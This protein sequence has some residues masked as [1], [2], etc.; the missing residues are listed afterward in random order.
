[1]EPVSQ[2]G[3]KPARAE[4]I[5]HVKPRHGDI[6]DVQGVQFMQRNEF[7]PCHPMHRVLDPDR[8]NSY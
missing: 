7:D 2:K 8:L 4:D 5:E 6:H 1:M 3:N